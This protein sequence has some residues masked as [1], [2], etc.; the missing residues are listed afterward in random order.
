MGKT[1]HYLCLIIASVPQD[2]LEWCLTSLNL[3]NFTLLYAFNVNV[4]FNKGKCHRV[5]NV[6]Q[7]LNYAVVFDMNLNDVMT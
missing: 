2:T 6:K 5:Q 3:R 4:K 7:V 1:Y